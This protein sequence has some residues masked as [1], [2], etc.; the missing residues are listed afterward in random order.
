MSL[1]KPHSAILSPAL[2][3]PTVQL[4]SSSVSIWPNWKYESLI[5]SWNRSFHSHTLLGTR[6]CWADAF[7]GGVKNVPRVNIICQTQ[8]E[9]SV[10]FCIL[11]LKWI[12]YCQIAELEPKGRSSLALDEW[13]HLRPRGVSLE[14][15]GRHISTPSLSPPWSYGEN[16][17][18]VLLPRSHWPLGLQFQCSLPPSLP[19]SHVYWMCERR[20]KGNGIADMR[21][22]SALLCCS[23]E[24]TTALERSFGEYSS[25]NITKWACLVCPFK[26]SYLNCW[27]YT[28]CI[29]LSSGIS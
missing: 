13:K 15:R 14:S 24:L 27:F 23:V 1:A 2:L 6:D 5:P 10:D 29:F 12:F 9:S 21:V 19:L 3:L 16:M 8:S 7:F 18:N 26:F 11:N 4:P 17:N 22:S 28:C 20:K 25:W